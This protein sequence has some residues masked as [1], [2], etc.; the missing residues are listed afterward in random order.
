MN[1]TILQLYIYDDD[2]RFTK[3]DQS[4]F[5]TLVASRDWIK[6]YYLMSDASW[7]DGHFHIYFRGKVSDVVLMT[8]NRF[9]ERFG[10][11]LQRT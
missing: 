3:E 4:I 1:Q 11:K 6:S 5:G 8:I 2:V 9:L 7:Y 10:T